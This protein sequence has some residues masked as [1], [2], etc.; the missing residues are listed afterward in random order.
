[1][2]NV[3]NIQKTIDTMREYGN[4]VYAFDMDLYT[5]DISENEDHPYSEC[6]TA[7]CIASFAVIAKNGSIE[8]DQPNVAE[9]ARDFL[10][11]GDHASHL[12]SP[13]NNPAWN[14]TLDQGIAILEHLKET[15]TIDW[16]VPFPEMKEEDLNGNTYRPEVVYG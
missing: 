9:E 5:K 14:A 1:M 15:S 3:D 11:L 8:V 10:G 13:N 2:I 16:S 6:G 7:C 12:F 4:K